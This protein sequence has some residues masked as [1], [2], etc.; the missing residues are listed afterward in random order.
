MTILLSIVAFLLPFALW[1]P[2]F[3]GVFLPR[4]ILIQLTA[5]V[6]LWMLARRE[7]E[8]LAPTIWIP[9]CFF[10]GIA[11]LVDALNANPLLLPCI[12]RYLTWVAL[13]G[14]VVIGR[15]M[16][17]WDLRPVMICSVSGATISAVIS[18]F[19]AA[20]WQ[21]IPQA[22][23]PAAL[24]VNR[25]LLAE[26]LI[27]IIPACVYLTVMHCKIWALP[28][29]VM[30]AGLALTQCRGAML[31]LAM[32]VCVAIAMGKKSGAGYNSRTLW[33]GAGCLASAFGYAFWKY[34]IPAGQAGVILRFRQWFTTLP[35]LLDHPFGVGTGGFQRWFPVYD[36]IVAVNVFGFP[37]SPHNDVLWFTVE[38]G[39]PGILA[40]ACVGWLL[41]RS[42]W[43]NRADPLARA[44]GTSLTALFVASNFSFTSDNTAAWFLPLL[45]AG[46]AGREK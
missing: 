21:L 10:V 11:F 19:Q 1:L 32:G 5:A 41:A 36:R 16:D 28:V 20:G 8:V 3:D 6:G 29:A 45:L 15:T 46:Y 42:L 2:A 30:L 24:F 39:I 18:F 17:E 13:F 31:G 7:W 38:Y 40:L 23:H 35:M 33:L 25:N 44:A 26:Y 12:H 22:F 14:L 9:F 34:T 4:L 37:R 27:A 43:I